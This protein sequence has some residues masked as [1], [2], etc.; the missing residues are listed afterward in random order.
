MRPIKTFLTNLLSIME[1][2]FIAL[3]VA[4]LIPM[5]LGF[6]WYHPKVFGDMWMRAAGVT[7][8]QTRTGNMPLIFGLSFVFSL[9]LAFVMNTLAYHDS[10][11]KGALFYVTNRTL[12]PVPGSPEANWLEY[13]VAHLADTCRTF[14]HGA[15]HGTSFGILLVLPVFATNAL[16]ERKSLKYVAINAGYWIVCLALMGGLVAAWK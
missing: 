12:E 3:I 1:I 6:V 10:F 2:N 15:F 14:R 13:Y 11:V 8:E 9:M 4:A 16:F 5:A 7:E